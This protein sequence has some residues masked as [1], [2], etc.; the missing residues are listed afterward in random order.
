MSDFNTDVSSIIERVTIASREKSTDKLDDIFN[1][2]WRQD[3]ETKSYFLREV[4]LNLK[5]NSETLA[6]LCAYLSGIVN[7]PEDSMKHYNNPVWKAF[8]ILTKYGKIP[9]EDF[10]PLPGGEVS[11]PKSTYSS[12]PLK[13]KRQL[14]QISHMEVSHFKDA[15]V[16]FK[17]EQALKGI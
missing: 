6:W 1:D 8:R 15:E 5:D 12:L 7:T 16:A 9:F 2:I 13:V 11:I 4:A 10:T 17:V 14:R 3:G